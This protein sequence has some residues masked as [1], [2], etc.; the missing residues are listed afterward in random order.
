MNKKFVAS[1]P[2]C[3]GE[4]LNKMTTC[5][6]YFMSNENFDLYEC[7]NCGFVL[8][9]NVPSKNEIGRY[10]QSETYISHSNTN[11]GLM[12]KVYHVVR[13]YMMNKKTSLVKKSTGL[14]KGELLDVGAGIGLFASKMHS[15]GWNVQ[16][17]EP[18]NTA[19][20]TAKKNYGL[21]LYGDSLWQELPTA[22]KDLITLWHVL[23]HIPNLNESWEKFYRVLKPTGKLIIAVPNSKSFDANYYGPHWAAYD[24]P[25][26]LWHFNAQTM[27]QIAL[28]HGFRVI[29][30]LPMPFD[31][32]YISMMTEK[33]LKNSLPIIRGSWIGL[34]GYLKALGDKNKSSSLIYVLQKI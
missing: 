10:Y 23:E 26:H 15:K 24:V 12:N 19:R 14:E 34:R 20:H 3:Q 1:C 25:R 31:G 30:T 13:N 8:T 2:I 27:Q 4:S 11:K 33:N 17:I 6:D 21:D 9:A 28:K 32:F 29:K 5:K 22:S 7:R 16:G 18:S